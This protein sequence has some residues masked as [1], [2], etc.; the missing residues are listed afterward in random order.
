MHVW[1]PSATL[2]RR[3]QSDT[4]AWGK[5]MLAGADGRALIEETRKKMSKLIKYSATD[6]QPRGTLRSHIARPLPAPTASLALPTPRPA[7]LAQ[8]TPQNARGARST[9]LLYSRGN[10]LPAGDVG[11]PA[12]GRACGGGG[13][14]YPL[15]GRQLLVRCSLLTA[16]SDVSSAF[17]ADGF[18]PI[19]CEPPDCMGLNDRY[20]R[21]T[22]A[23]L[24]TLATHI[25]LSIASQSPL[26]CLSFTSYSPLI[27]HTSTVH[28]LFI[29]H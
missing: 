11:V 20:D 16:R 6:P 3:R 24:A 4:G 14:F 27:R 2:V 12:A 22:L 21:D 19:A 28:S 25:C 10:R 26:I 18:D 9:D 5:R 8:A 1:W 17:R 7:A 13:V 23:P 15:D 29:R